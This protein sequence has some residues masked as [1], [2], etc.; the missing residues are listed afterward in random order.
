VS[1]QEGIQL[2][3]QTAGGLLAPAILMPRAFMYVVNAAAAALATC[4]FC[5]LCCSQQDL[6][7]A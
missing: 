6:Q 5:S 2:N 3:A 4:L 7:A 1:I